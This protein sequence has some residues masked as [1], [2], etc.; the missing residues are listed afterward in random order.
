VAKRTPQLEECIAQLS[1]L[2][3]SCVVRLLARGVTHGTAGALT[4]TGSC[5]VAL[6]VL[7][8]TNIPVKTTTTTT[9]R[10]T[11]VGMPKSVRCT[12][13][14]RPPSRPIRRV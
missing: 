4:R 11:P 1:I 13:P 12:M 9:I 6:T 5:S 2:V 14:L 10:V 8:T 7:T 3:V